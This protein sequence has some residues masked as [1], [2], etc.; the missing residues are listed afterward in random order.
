[1]KTS[2]VR[3]HLLRSSLVLWL[4]LPA[5]QPPAHRLPVVGIYWDLVATGTASRL[6]PQPPING[7]AKYSFRFTPDSVYHYLNTTE[8]EVIDIGPYGGDF[9]YSHHFTQRNDSLFFDGGHYRIASLSSD[10][11]VLSSGIHRRVYAAAREQQK[12]KRKL[13][14]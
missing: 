9:I 7:H 5:C 10:S 4:L 8:R 1:M 3:R 13:K 2:H 6:S 12:V 11:L 14:K